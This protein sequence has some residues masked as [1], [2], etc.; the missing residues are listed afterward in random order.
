M[1]ISHL[2]GQLRISSITLNPNWDIQEIGTFILSDFK[3]VAKRK[4]EVI[5]CPGCS[6]DEDAKLDETGGY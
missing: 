4:C 2:L 3:I 5:E 6:L 1:E